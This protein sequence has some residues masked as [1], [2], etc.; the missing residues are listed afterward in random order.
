[1]A[2]W[3]CEE[4]SDLGDRWEFV[5]ERECRRDKSVD[6]YEKNYTHTSSCTRDDPCTN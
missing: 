2:A 1:M 3:G 5:R 4:M 6:D